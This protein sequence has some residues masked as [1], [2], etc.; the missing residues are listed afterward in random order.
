MG[1]QAQHSERILSFMPST[2]M[3]C[4]LTTLTV[5]QNDGGVCRDEVL[6]KHQC[7][8]RQDS[9]PQKL[10]LLRFSVCDHRMIRAL[11]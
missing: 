9:S 3:P 10:R 1:I 7:Q 5:T 4:G 2:R 8:V 11:S 6:A